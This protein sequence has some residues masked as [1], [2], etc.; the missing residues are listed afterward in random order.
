VLRSDALS[1]GCSLGVMLTGVNPQT[2]DVTSS[3]PPP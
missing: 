1:R 3:S 2:G